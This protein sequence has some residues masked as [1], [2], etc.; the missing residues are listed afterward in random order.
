MGVFTQGESPD[1]A[2]TKANKSRLNDPPYGKVKTDVDGIFADFEK[3]E[4]NMSFPGFDVNE[5]EFY[6]NMKD[7]R[8]RLRFRNGSRVQKY[9]QRTKYP[10]NPFFIRCQDKIRRVR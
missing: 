7:G 5:Y 3:K 6:Q 8:R 10:R 4:G 1:M 9:M 2:A